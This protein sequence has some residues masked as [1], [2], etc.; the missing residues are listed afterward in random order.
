MFFLGTILPMPMHEMTIQTSTSIQK[1]KS[2]QDILN[3]D[4]II[5][6]TGV[7][8]DASETSSCFGVRALE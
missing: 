5:P 4:G 7:H 1:G 3:I 8:S 6:D 2:N